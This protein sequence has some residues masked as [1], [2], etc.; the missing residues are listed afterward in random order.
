MASKTK[1]ELVVAA[2]EPALFY[3]SVQQAEMDLE[4]VDVR[5]GVFP[6]AYGPDGQIFKLEAIGDRVRIT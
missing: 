4:A 2:D 1:I 5:D 6:I 3:S